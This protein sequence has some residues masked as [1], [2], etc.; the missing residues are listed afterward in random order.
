MAASVARTLHRS[1]VAQAK[2]NNTRL[3]DRLKCIRNLRLAIANDPRALAGS[4][5][6]SNI[7]ETLAAEVLPLAD[8]C[9]FLEAQATKILRDRTL[10]TGGRPMWLWGNHVR[11]R[12]EPLGVVLV[13]GPGNYPLMLPG[14]QAVQAL[15]AGNSVLWK[16]APGYQNAARHLAKMADAAG[17]PEDVLQILSEDKEAATHA[18]Q[19]GVNKVVL[20]GSIHTGRAVSRALAET[21]TPAVMELSGCDAVFVL[22]DAD[23]KTVASCLAFG[24][25]L[26]RSQT[27][28]APRRVF[29]SDAM[30]ERI[31]PALLEKLQA[32]EMSAP[33]LP[34]GDFAQARAKALADELSDEAVAAGAKRIPTIEG[35]TLLD[36]V[37]P[38]MKIAQSDLFVPVLSF[39]RVSS[40]NEAIAQSKCC[41]YALGASVFGSTGDSQEFARNIDAGC[42]VINDMIA[43]TADPRIPFGGRGLSGFGTTRGAAGLEEMTQLKAVVT[44]RKWFRPHLDEPTP[45]DADVLES[46]IRLEHARSPLNQ[47]SVVPG[48][49]ASTISQIK[50]RSKSR[51]SL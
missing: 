9:K 22:D 27:C 15:V 3:K 14:I 51:K 39:I 13:I 50:H 19:A 16:P 46:L 33:S 41:P 31:T 49:I 6:R 24:L 42:V 35:V 12:R 25:T 34:N 32:R 38:T 28:I 2:W 11:L 48:M 26:N 8:A 7:A 1:Q 17:I 36:D 23:V 37:K 10:A 44:S 43:P 5:G 20:T 40:M 47:L 4:T 29:A 21:T 45:V 30:V 18:M